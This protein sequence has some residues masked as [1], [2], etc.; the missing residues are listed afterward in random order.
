MLW[1]FSARS[2]HQL[3]KNQGDKRVLEQASVELGE[4]LELFA[5]DVAEEAI[6]LA[7]NKGYQI[8]KEEHVK[9]ALR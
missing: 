8:V 3:I 2:M 6:A 7:E 1:S 9:K 4:I 5:G